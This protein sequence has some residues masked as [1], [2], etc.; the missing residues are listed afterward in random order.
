MA[1]A[2]RQDVEAL[3]AALIAT[4]TAKLELHAEANDAPIALLDLVRK[5]LDQES[6]HASLPTVSEDDRPKRSTLTPPSSEEIGNAAVG[7]L[8]LRSVRTA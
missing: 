4:L 8:G 2:A 5:V 1:A 6:I 7:T 3:H